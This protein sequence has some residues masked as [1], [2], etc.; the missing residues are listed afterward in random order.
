LSALGT[1][2]GEW[3]VAAIGEVMHLF[4]SLLVITGLFAMIFRFLPD[5]RI[6]WRDVWLGA[7][8]TT[9]L[10]VAG[11]TLIGMYLGHS[12]IGSTYGAAGS[13]AVLLLWFYYSAQIFLFGA[14]LTQQYA[15]R[16]GHPIEPVDHAERR[17]DADSPADKD[18]QPVADPSS[19]RAGKDGAKKE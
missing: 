8:V 6:R 17:G 2:L 4:I 12:T 9:C 7:F 14:E 18:K 1:W 5:A 10:F 11:K 16:Y 3:V 13:L 19:S 15:R